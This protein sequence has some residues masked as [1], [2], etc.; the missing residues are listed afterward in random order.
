MNQKEVDDELLYEYI[1]DNA[2]IDPSVEV[3]YPTPAISMGKKKYRN[4][5]YPIALCTFGNFVFV[6]A[7]PKSKKTFFV[8]M[9]VSAYLSGGNK[10]TGN[11]KGAMEGNV[12]HIDTEQGDFHAKMVMQ[13]PAIMSG[14]DKLE[15]K[16]RY[17][18][19]ALRPHSYK[20]R[21]L[22]ID[23]YLKHNKV[24]FLVIDGIA[25]LVSDVN[26]LEEC[27]LVSQKLM[28]WSYKYNLAIVTVIHTNFGSEKPTGHL[29]SSIEKKCEAQ[30]DLTPS[31]SGVVSVKCK[32]SRN[33]S[34]KE[35]DFE[36]NENGIPYI[37]EHPI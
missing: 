35:F 12:L 7:P 2:Y 3:D 9:L 13:R 32:R 19:Y 31:D 10:H 23:Q 27:N 22:F 11:M 29:G 30:I 33:F 37:I 25:D 34:F 1:L 5:E 4:K 20:E 36:V 6:Q 24:K 8:S 15:Y 14:V 26:N 21:I 17:K 16:E 18:L 28:E